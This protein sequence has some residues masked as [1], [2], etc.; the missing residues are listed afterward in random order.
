MSRSPRTQPAPSTPPRVH[1]WALAGLGCITALVWW[2][3]LANEFVN[4]DDPTVLLNNPALSAPGVVGW[5][6]TTTVIDHYQPL[7]W[8][9]WSALIRLFGLNAPVFHA[10]SLVG[11]VVSACL[12][13]ALAWRLSAAALDDDGERR[14]VAACAALFFAVHPL[15]VEAVAWASAFPYVLSLVVLLLATLAYLEYTGAIVRSRAA[16]WLACAIV[17]YLSSQLVR[18]T[19]IAFPLVLLALNVYPLRRPI[20][21]RAL[22]DALPFFVVAIAVAVAE[23]G[24]RDVTSLQEIGPGARGTMAA[25]APLVYL[26]RTVFPVR[27]SPLDPLPIAPNV[28]WLRLSVGLAALAASSVVAWRVRRR[29]PA[30]AVGGASYLLLLGPV[31]GLTPSGIQATADRYMYVP[32]VVVA[33]LA[34]ALAARVWPRD[35]LRL[36]A[37]GAALAVVATLG[38]LTWRQTRWW[39][40]SILLWTRAIVLD[41]G[42]DVAT[43]NLAVALADAGRDDEAIEQYTRTLQLVPDHALARQQLASLEARRDEHEGDRLVQEGRLTDAEAAYS[44]ALAR[45]PGRLHAR[46]RHGVVLVQL[47]RARDGASDLQT[48][49]DAG[50]DDTAVLNALAFVRSATGRFADA[51]AVLQRGVDRYP[52]DMNLAHNLARLLATAPDATVRDGRR[53]MELALRVRDRLGD[54]NPRVLDTLA[55]AYAEA[56]QVALARDTLQRAAARA[57]ASGDAALAAEITEHARRYT[58]R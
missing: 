34:G 46:A 40:D 43:Y 22:L 56:G 17:L 10:A 28:D 55:A 30:F 38:T 20:D 50:V 23:W 21:R 54:G 14:I 25:V 7:A 16:V 29:W 2:P 47:G 4:W 26:G 6:F 27:L 42:N 39:H 12:V 3:A 11:H 41:P 52:A 51:A 49:Y 48:V 9:A 57:R 13:Y 33:I 19:A 37:F 53:A 32:G 18:P 35:R 15:R 58:G 1:A 24:A 44:R 36:A 31:I 45:D 8:L 5:A